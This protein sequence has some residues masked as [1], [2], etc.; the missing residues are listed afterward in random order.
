MTLKREYVYG[1]NGSCPG[2]WWFVLG[3]TIFDRK[4]VR[5]F[6][7]THKVE[8]YMSHVIIG[9][10]ILKLLDVFL[11]TKKMLEMFFFSGEQ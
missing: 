2:S 1:Y 5:K 10:G 4:L 7:N 8:R 11:S 9:C 6:E 3:S